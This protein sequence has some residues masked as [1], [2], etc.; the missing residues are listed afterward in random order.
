MVVVVPV[1]W[2]LGGAH[3]TGEGKEGWLNAYVSRPTLVAPE[4]ASRKPLI[5]LGERRRTS[6]RNRVFPTLNRGYQNPLPM[7]DLS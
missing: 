3:G 5:T 2:V 1:P 6:Q 7:L 4:P